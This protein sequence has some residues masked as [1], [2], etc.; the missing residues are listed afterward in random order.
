MF[1][2]VDIGSV[3]VPYGTFAEGYTRRAHHTGESQ[4]WDNIF[5]PGVGLVK[6]VDYAADNA[7]GIMELTTVIPEPATICLLTLGGLA[8]LRRKS[9]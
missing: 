6:E 5:V 4:Y 8:L 7:P 9:A 2:I 1:E 3:T